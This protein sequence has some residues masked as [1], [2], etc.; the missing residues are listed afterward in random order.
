M[1]NAMKAAFG[2]MLLAGVGAMAATPA[3]AAVSVGIGIGVPAGDPCYAAYPYPAYCQYPVFSGPVYING[4]WVTGVHRY[5]VI[6]G[7]RVFWVNGG[8]HHVR[9]G[10]GHWLGARHAIHR[11]HRAYHHAEH[12]IHRAHHVIRHERREERREHHHR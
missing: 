6:G 4:R 12:A 7:R 11:A 1:K 3:S 8:W 5:R 2:A 9:Y 10:H